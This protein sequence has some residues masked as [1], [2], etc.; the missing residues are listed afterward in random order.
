MQVIDADGHVEE[1]EA[2]FKLLEPEWQPR[3]P[4]PLTFS[5]D[6][7]YNTRNAVWLIDS[8]VYPRWI[9]KDTVQF[10]TPTTMERAK[11]K[12]V[13]VGAQELTDVAARLRDLDRLKIDIQVVYPTMFL[14]TTTDDIEFEAALFRAYNTFMGGVFKQSGGR[15]RFSALV[16]TRD[17]RLAAEEARRAKELG[18][19]SVFLLGF[20][21]NNALGDRPMWPLYEE[22]AALDL[23][24]CIHFGWGNP[25][26]T[27]LF[28]LANNFNSGAIPVLMAFFSVMTSGVMEQLPRLRFAFLEAGSMWLPYLLGEVQK[29]GGKD[30]AAYFREGRAYISCEASDDVP[31]LVRYIGEDAI[32]AAS[33]YPHADVFSEEDMVKSFNAREDLSASLREKLLSANARALYRF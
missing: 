19:A 4:L 27:A 23:P 22:A 25:A 32:V 1:S 15:I 5:A 14:A 3:R 30:P 6:T 13:A 21:W 17:S 20:A 8:R 24:V 33:D 12:P 18:A 10:S 28:D 16:S 7:V 9:G 11:Q 31:Y 26:F 29:N 2:I